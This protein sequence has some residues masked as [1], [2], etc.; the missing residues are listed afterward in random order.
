M[1]KVVNQGIALPHTT[2]DQGHIRGL[3]YLPGKNRSVPAATVTGK[4]KQN[5]KHTTAGIRQ[6]SPT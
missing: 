5:K 2:H 3:T 1:G 6:W 4:Q